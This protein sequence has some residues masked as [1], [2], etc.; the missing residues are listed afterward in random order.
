[1]VLHTAGPKIGLGTQG[2]LGGSPPTH[3]RRGSGL[4]FP[5]Y[6][7]DLHGLQGSPSCPSQALM[8]PRAAP[9]PPSSPLPA[10][11]SSP[12][13]GVHT[14]HKA[15][16]GSPQAPSG[17]PA[18]AHLPPSAWRPCPRA[19]AWPRSPLPCTPQGGT[20][21]G[22]L[23]PRGAV[24]GVGREGGL[25]QGQAHLR[26]PRALVTRRVGPAEEQEWG[27]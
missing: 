12:P 4:L 24:G 20:G 15:P 22:W 18:W 3:G 13:P 26:S 17:S 21:C 14:E 25:L 2:G 19:F 23:L 11:G 9:G 7:C 10:W 8:R 16:S 27:L 1:M 6:P 5:M